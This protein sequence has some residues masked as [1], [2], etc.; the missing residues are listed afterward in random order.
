MG[1]FVKRA[2]RVAA[3]V[4]SFA[5]TAVAMAQT[6]PAITTYASPVDAIDAVGG[7]TQGMAPILYGMAVLSS[8]IVLGIAWIKK[9]RGAGK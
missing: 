2:A 3:G 8:G 4:G 7:S 5:L 6:T 1:K 9:S